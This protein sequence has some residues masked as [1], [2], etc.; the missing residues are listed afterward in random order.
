MACVRG[1][2]GAYLLAVPAKPPVPLATNLVGAVPKVR[3]RQYIYDSKEIW[4]ARGA[5][6]TAMGGLGFPELDSEVK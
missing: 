5:K 3:V 6:R 4:R 1:G 2:D